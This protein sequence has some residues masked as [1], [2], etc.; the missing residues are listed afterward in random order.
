MIVTDIL[1]MSQ[2][3]YKEEIVGIL[4]KKDN[5]I[6]GLAKDLKTNQTTIARKVKELENCNVVD[7]R[8]EGKNKVYFLKKT[9]EAKEFVYITEHKKFLGALRKYVI[10][11][12]IVNEIKNEKK[13]K[14]AVI[15]GSYAKDRAT[16]SSD[17]DIYI[18]STDR[19][20]KKRLEQVN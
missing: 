8:L 17:I 2:K 3:D 10:L 4:L 9:L 11:R 14:L 16:R 1:H 5:H 20:L 7:F 18:E 6:R 12:K 13:V 19:K 15:F